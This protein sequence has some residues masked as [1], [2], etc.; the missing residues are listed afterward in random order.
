MTKEYF[1]PKAILITGGGRRLGAAIAKGLAKNNCAIA[2]HYNQSEEAVESLAEHL[3]DKGCET[4]CIQADLSDVAQVERLFATAH[5]T[6]GP[7]D[8]LVNNASIFDLC[9]FADTTK[10]AI[11]DNMDLHVIAP[12]V[13]RRAFA[14]QN[15]GGVIINMLD[16]RMVD[17]DKNH[18]PYHLSK[19]IL[20][21]LTRIMA[22]EFAPAIRVNAIAP[23]LI[24]PPYG[25]DQAYLESLAHTTLLNTHGT[26]WDIAQAALYLVHA[27]FVTGQT[28]FVDGGRNLRGRM[29]E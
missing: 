20:A 6:L 22:V 9:G 4:V 3:R 11:Q 14:A 19:R 8:V 18:L 29:Y 2:L 25:E 7:F 23:G 12:L 24:M 13:L 1:V 5:E 28:I 26:A 21:D 10:E 16:A 15:N 27:A 17:Y